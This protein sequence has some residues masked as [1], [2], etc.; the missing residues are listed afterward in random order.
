MGTC[1]CTTHSVFY[2][3]MSRMN[4]YVHR[5]YLLVSTCRM[6]AHFLIDTFYSHFSPLCSYSFHIYQTDLECRFM[7]SICIRISLFPACHVTTV[8]ISKIFPKITVLQL[9][10]VR[11][12]KQKSKK[13]SKVRFLCIIIK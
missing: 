1:F 4:M 7:L 11:I 12:S 8:L 5:T 9:L 6:H 3:P 13:S 2:L 10:N